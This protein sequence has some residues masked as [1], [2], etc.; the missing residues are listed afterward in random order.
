METYQ[1]FLERINTFEKQEMFLGNDYFYGNPS[2]AQ[3]VDG[4]NQFQPFWGDTIVFQLD[5]D[6]KKRL[7]ECVEYLYQEV[8]ECF[9]QQLVTDTFHMT[10]H[11]LSNSPFLYNIAE[12]V[13]KN[14]LK[15]I[16]IFKQIKP[17]K[18][19]MKSKYI[20]NMVSTSL[21]LGLYPATEEDYEKLMELYE[22][23]HKVKRLPYPFTPHITLAYYNVYGFDTNSAR[24][25]EAIVWELNQQEIEFTLDTCDLYYQKFTTM[26][27]YISIIKP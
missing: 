23:F 19:K 5:S 16:E 20:F 25:L 14:E 3:K 1:Q 2:I 4:Q 11:D 21:V 9:A 10:L 7:E 24:K 8:E 22:M 26:N 17:Q 6:V 27:D 15:V 12:E 18:I 13:F